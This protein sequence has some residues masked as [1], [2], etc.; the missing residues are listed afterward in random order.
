MKDLGSKFTFSQRWKQSREQYKTRCKIST[1][2]ELEHTE[3]AG[4]TVREKDWSGAGF[5]KLGTTDI[6]GRITPRWLG[7]KEFTCQCRTHRFNRWVRKY[8]G[9]GNGYPLQYSCLENHMERGAWWATVHGVTKSDTTKGLNNN[10]NNSLFGIICPVCC[11]MMLQASLTSIHHMSI[12]PPP[13]VVTT[14]PNIP[15]RAQSPHTENH[16]LRIS[17]KVA[18]RR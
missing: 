10:I 18:N 5:L 16:C 8:P 7:S 4:N 2:P 15:W 1:C 6:W 12:Q 13:Q 14:L 17:G 3:N 11:R 9:E